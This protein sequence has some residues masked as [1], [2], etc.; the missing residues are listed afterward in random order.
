[1][2]HKVLDKEELTLLLSSKRL[3]SN[4]LTS[5]KDREDEVTIWWG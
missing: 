2:S 4:E 1:V 3:Y 5:S